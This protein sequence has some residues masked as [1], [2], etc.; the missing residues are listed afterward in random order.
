MSSMVCDF[1]RAAKPSSVAT[2]S[3]MRSRPQAGQS[4]DVLQCDVVAERAITAERNQVRQLNQVS[5]AIG[6]D[7]IDMPEQVQVDDPG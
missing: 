3:C 7:L 1:A 2:D 5:E 6:R 4:R